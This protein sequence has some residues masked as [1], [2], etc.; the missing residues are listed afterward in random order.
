[1]LYQTSARGR[2]RLDR[3]V[4]HLLRHYAPDTRIAPFRSVFG[5]DEIAFDVAGVNVPCGSLSRFPYRHYHSASDTPSAVDDEGFEAFVGLV[6]R[7]I[8]VLENDDLLV[9]RFSG[10][11]CLADPAIDLYLS[12][13]RVSGVAVDSASAYG[14]LMERLPDDES[15]AIAGRATDRFFALMNAIPARADGSASVLDIA[16]AVDLPFAVVETYIGMWKEKGLLDTV[17]RNP[18][19]DR[20]A[21][22]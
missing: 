5:N 20:R 6:L 11:P 9:P 21:A 2:S 10:L 16:E 1:M 3:I 14:K 4:A 8:D 7:I 17:W 15:R 22:S 19:D 18:F 13:P 12:P